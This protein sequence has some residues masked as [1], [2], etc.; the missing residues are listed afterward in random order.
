MAKI[1]KGLWPLT[2]KT[3]TQEPYIRDRQSVVFLIPY[4]QRVT[5]VWSLTRLE[6]FWNLTLCYLTFCMCDIYRCDSR[7]SVWGSFILKTGR[8]NKN[9]LILFDEVP[10]THLE[11]STV[12]WI[13]LYFFSYLKKMSYF[14]TRVMYFEGV[15]VKKFLE[16]L[17]S[18]EKNSQCFILLHVI[19]I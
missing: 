5:L 6:Q 14:V 13:F 11:I 18:I 10:L 15:F 2:F 4:D 12:S 1:D 8:P 17:N 3:I 9:I 7:D 16:N 19:P